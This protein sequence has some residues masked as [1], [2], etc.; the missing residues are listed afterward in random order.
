MTSITLDCDGK[1]VDSIITWCDAHFGE[2]NWTWTSQFP[3]WH[4][5]F[6]LPNEQAVAWFKLA[7]Q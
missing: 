7:W 5:T 2:K 4:Y 3:S 1:D 6:Y